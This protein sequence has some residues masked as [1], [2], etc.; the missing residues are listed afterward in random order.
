MTNINNDE[1]PKHNGFF[2]QDFELENLMI[3]LSILWKKRTLD[4]SSHLIAL[5]SSFI[6]F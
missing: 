4:F 1:F 2:L 5:L 6:E 3:F